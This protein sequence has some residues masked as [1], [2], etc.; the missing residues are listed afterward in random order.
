MA[1]SVALF[2]IHLFVTLPLH[3]FIY[4]EYHD[5][6][7]KKKQIK[8]EHCLLSEIAL[9]TISSVTS[10]LTAKLLNDRLMLMIHSRES[11]CKGLLLIVLCKFIFH[12]LHRGLLPENR[13]SH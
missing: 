2:L 13:R 1:A 3:S 12:P 11:S 8:G 10:H 6:F 4:K 7:I 9:N 5:S